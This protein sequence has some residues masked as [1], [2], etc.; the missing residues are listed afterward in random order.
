MPHAAEVEE[1]DAY[2]DV[3]QAEGEGIAMGIEPV[4]E[5]GEGK[6]EPVDLEVVGAASWFSPTL[7]NW[8]LPTG[9]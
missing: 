2:E 1:E 9:P 4:A 5:E 3:V 8:V 6:D 7:R